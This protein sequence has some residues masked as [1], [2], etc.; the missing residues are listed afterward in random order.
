MLP[1]T[2][3]TDE[4]VQARSRA[5]APVKSVAGGIHRA[6]LGRS[7]RMTRRDAEDVPGRLAI[8]TNGD[9]VKIVTTVPK[10]H[11]TSGDRRTQDVTG[12]P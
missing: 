8:P 5:R 4:R 3:M 10:R 12:P 1:A 2:G 9:A 11:A 6:V 7:G